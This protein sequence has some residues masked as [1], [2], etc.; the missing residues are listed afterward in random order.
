MVVRI[1]VSLQDRILPKYSADVDSVFRFQ[2]LPRKFSKISIA[3]SNLKI[4]VATN[5][6]MK[7]YRINQPKLNTSISL[8]SS[9]RKF[10]P[11]T[12]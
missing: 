5:K 12:Q 1:E 4:K 11:P 9:H 7:P 3:S 6:T 2:P 10:L 8:I